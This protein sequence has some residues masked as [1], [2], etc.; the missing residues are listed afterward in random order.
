MIAYEFSQEERNAAL[1]QF[2]DRTFPGQAKLLYCWETNVFTERST[3]ELTLDECRDL[4]QNIWSKQLCLT[5]PVPSVLDGRGSIDARTTGSSIHLPRWARNKPIV[6]HELAH[7]VTDLFDVQS[8][9][10]HSSKYVQVY[11]TLLGSNTRY[12]YTALRTS[13]RKYG[14]TVSNMNVWEKLKP[15]RA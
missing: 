3:Q 9:I 10:D 14:L 2:D 1:A 7:F 6:I 5:A 11:L 13:A 15:F 12:K 4:I 8:S